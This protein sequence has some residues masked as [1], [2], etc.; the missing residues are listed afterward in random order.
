MTL[1]NNDKSKATSERKGVI[2][3]GACLVLTIIG[4]A[5]VS[6]RLLDMTGVADERGFS[7]EERKEKARRNDAEYGK[8]SSGMSMFNPIGWFSKR[9]ADKMCAD[10]QIVATASALIKENTADFGKLGL[11]AGKLD[12]ARIGDQAGVKQLD[13]MSIRDNEIKIASEPLPAHYDQNLNRAVCQVSYMVK[14]LGYS[15]NSPMTATYTVQEGK[16]DW[17]VTLVSLN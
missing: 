8:T 15:E 13:S 11:A 7:V 17:V 14:G 2:I 10:G 1:P 9:T 6:N 12:N 5:L 16:Q 4:L 3:A